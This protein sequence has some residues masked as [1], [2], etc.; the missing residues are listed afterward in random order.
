MSSFLYRR[1]RP[2]ILHVCT[3]A[4][5]G[6]ASQN[7]MHMSSGENRYMVSNATVCPDSFRNWYMGGFQHA[8]SKFAVRFAVWPLQAYKLSYGIGWGGGVETSVATD[9]SPLNNCI[10]CQVNVKILHVFRVNILS[11]NIAQMSM[12]PVILPSLLLRL[13]ELQINQMLRFSHGMNAIYA[14]IRLN[15]SL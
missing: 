5:I 11:S 8:E 2:K 13:P 4:L 9:A 3:Y 10:S 6:D 7:H 1:L 12:I 14:V 15:L